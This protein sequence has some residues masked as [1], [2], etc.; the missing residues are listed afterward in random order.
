MGVIVC[1][2][3]LFI[4]EAFCIFIGGSLMPLGQLLISLLY[5]IINVFTFT[6]L[7]F[8]IATVVHKPNAFA[9]LSTVIG[10]LVGFLAGIYLP[11][12][13]L[14]N[15]VQTVLKCLPM[16]HGASLLRDCLTKEI[17]DKTFVNCPEELING[18]KEAMGISIYFNDVPVSN[19]FKIIFL[20]LVGII[21]I[22]ISAAMH[23]KRYAYS[24]IG[25]Y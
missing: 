17:M 10:S 21:F 3:T 14:P 22:G 5:I 16:I 7:M 1:L 15:T 20:L 4:G 18:Y 12:G 11:M 25:D 8:F 13:A 2:I 24:M 19:L 9:G 23:K 6:C